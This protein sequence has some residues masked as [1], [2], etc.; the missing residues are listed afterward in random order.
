[1]RERELKRE[2]KRD[3]GKEND[4]ER[5]R[6]GQSILPPANRIQ[7][8]DLEYSTDE[9]KKEMGNNEKYKK[10]EIKIV[11]KG[12]KERKKKQHPDPQYRSRINLL[13]Y[14]NKN[15]ECEMENEREKKS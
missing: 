11:K 13:E 3:R 10:K 1:M 15:L 4:R 5:N 6:Q 7:D 12:A 8:T 9:R 14:L 2:G